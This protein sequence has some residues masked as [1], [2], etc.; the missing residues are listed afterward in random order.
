MLTAAATLY[1]A[2]RGPRRVDVNDTSEPE[3]LLIKQ[4]ILCYRFFLVR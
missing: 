1:K 2:I 3:R 4:S